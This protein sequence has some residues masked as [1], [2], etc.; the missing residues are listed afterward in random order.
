MN[1]NELNTLLAG[2]EPLKNLKPV[3]RDINVYEVLSA[4][5]GSVTAY[6]VNLND[7]PSCTCEDYEFNNDESEVCAHIAQVMVTADPLWSPEEMSMQALL[8]QMGEA[9]AATE[10]IRDL[11]AMLG[12]VDE[13]NRVAD[14]NASGDTATTENADAGGSGGSSSDGDE[15][16]VSDA[17]PAQEDEALMDQLGEWFDE[18]A[19]F[20]DFDPDIV[21]LNWVNADGVE[22]VEVDR[23]PFDAGFYDDGE[24]QDKEEFDDQKEKVKDAALNREQFEWFGEPDYVWFIPAGAVTEVCG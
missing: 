17:T 6:T 24:W 1:T 7:G 20:A 4:R 21:D 8:N 12:S 22:G 14:A 19:E 2:E 10:R 5:N 9:K 18:A 23:Q 13:A 16:V 15:G 3:Q 11:E